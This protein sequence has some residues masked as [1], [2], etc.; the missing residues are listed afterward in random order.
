MVNKTIIEGRLMKEVAF[1]TLPSG[2]QVAR[3][4][5]VHTRKYQNKK[6]EWKEELSFF[7][8]DVYS[9]ALI[10]RVKRLGKGDRIIV[11]GQ[12]K[13]DKWTSDDSKSHS[14]IRVKASRI[15]LI[16][17]PKSASIKKQSLAHS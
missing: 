2:R 4:V 17:K 14:K 8:I 12:L 1:R 3:L 9:P 15:Q 16:S 13:Q 7:E 5:L 6:N 11:E 10:E